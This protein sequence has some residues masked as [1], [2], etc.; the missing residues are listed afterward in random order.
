[1]QHNVLASYVDGK[2]C[3]QQGDDPEGVRQLLKDAIKATIK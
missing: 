2:L 1:V 3:A